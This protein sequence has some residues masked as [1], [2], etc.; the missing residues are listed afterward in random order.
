MPTNEPVGSMANPPANELVDSMA[1]LS[2]N[3]S[4][5]A[6]DIDQEKLEARVII[7]VLDCRKYHRDRSSRQRVDMANQHGS[8]LGLPYF[9]NNE[10]EYLKSFAGD[11][12]MSLGEHIETTMLEAKRRRAERNLR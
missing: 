10:V 5:S 7:Y 1:N 12:H 6:A 3:N 8:Y 11:D 9:S 4:K 2:V